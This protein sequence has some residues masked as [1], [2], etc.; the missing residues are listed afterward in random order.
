MG[1]ELEHRVLI[2]VCIA[3]AAGVILFGVQTV[4]VKVLSKPRKG[5]TKL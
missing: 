3:V 1:D 5:E 4:A 2:A